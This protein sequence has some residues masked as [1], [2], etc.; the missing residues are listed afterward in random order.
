VTATWQLATPRLHLRRLTLDD[1]DLML[2][3]W[4][5]PAF[6]RN[7][8]DR[9]IRTHEQA[10]A[11]LEDGPLKLYAD[12]GYGPYVMVLRSEGSR[13]GICGLFRRD[14]LEHPDIGF[15]VLPD[16]CG[17]G[18]A[19]EAAMAV[20]EYARDEL[21]LEQL[22]AIVSPGNAPSIGLI[23]KLGLSFAGMITMPD[24]DREIC[25]YSGTLG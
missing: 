1:A 11:A 15:A 6:V 5:D 8:G 9:G 2:A 19:G 10:C 25:L 23:E 17:Q 13:I 24:D 20:L 16:Y 18:F 3:I 21:R 4:N 7:V 22:A 12:Y 14:N